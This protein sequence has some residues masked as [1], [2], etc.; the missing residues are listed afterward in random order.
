[1]HRQHGGKISLIG[2]SLGGIYAKSLAKQFPQQ[3]RQVITLGSPMAGDITE[4][5]LLPLYQ[6]VSGVQDGGA[7]LRQRVC[8]LAAPVRPA[9]E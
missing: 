1:M 6:W 3:V 7:S 8:A 4:L 2:W 5:G 9:P